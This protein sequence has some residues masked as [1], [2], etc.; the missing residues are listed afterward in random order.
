[1]S[2][3]SKLLGV[4]LQALTMI[5]FRATL[6]KVTWAR[7]MTATLQKENTRTMLNVLKLRLSCTPEVKLL[8]NERFLLRSYSVH[9]KVSFVRDHALCPDDVK[10]ASISGSYCPTG[11]Q[12]AR[13]LPTPGRRWL[14]QHPGVI[15][16]PMVVYR[17]DDRLL[18]WCCMEAVVLE[19]CIYSH[20]EP[21]TCSLIK[22]TVSCGN[23]IN[24]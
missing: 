6:T 21:C 12:L 20:T 4:Y 1:M 11:V 10:S 19:C 16:A 13:V 18:L 8:F 15:A 24:L 22:P 9:T 5:I 2:A 14:S 7:M 23:H 3:P 17:A